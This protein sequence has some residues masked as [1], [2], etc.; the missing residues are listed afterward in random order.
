MGIS[1]SRWNAMLK[2]GSL[3]YHFRHAPH[4]ENN[5][6]WQIYSSATQGRYKLLGFNEDWK[7]SRNFTAIVRL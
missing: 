5:D 4:Q 3:S 2:Q 1:L 7:D 6:F